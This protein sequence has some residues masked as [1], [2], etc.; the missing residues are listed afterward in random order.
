MTIPHSRTDSTRDDWRSPE[1]VQSLIDEFADDELL[2]TID[3]CASDDPS[4]W[5]CDWNRSRLTP[6]AQPLPNHDPF[7]PPGLVYVNPPYGS[8]LRQWSKAIARWRA[9]YPIVVALVPAR[10]GSA[11]W[12]RLAVPGT[13]VIVPY[14]RLT[15]IGAPTVAAFPSA[16]VVGGTSPDLR[17]RFSAAFHGDAWIVQPDPRWCRARCERCGH[18]DAHHAALRGLTRYGEPDAPFCSGGNGLGCRCRKFVDVDR[19]DPF[20]LVEAPRHWCELS[21]P[22]SVAS[23]T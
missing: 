9:M 15:F 12:S 3:P 22:A 1:W 14:E 16:F 7:D 21:P 2:C 17:L 10:P 23:G 8:A 11:W 18:D 5:F 19:S 6:I 13:T 20:P 4:H